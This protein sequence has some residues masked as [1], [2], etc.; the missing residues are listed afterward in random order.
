MGQ[1]TKYYSSKQEHM[2]ADYLGWSVVSGSGARAFH[3]GDIRSDD[4]LGECKTHVERV[5]RIVIYN[6]VWAKIISEAT[7]VFKTPVLFIDNGSQRV[8]STWCVIPRNVVLSHDIKP[9]HFETD[10][11]CINISKTQ[12]SF[13]HNEMIRQYKILHTNNNSY[14]AIV[15]SVGNHNVAIYRLDEFRNVFL[16]G[17]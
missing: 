8:D 7:S 1:P 12:T 13:N 6:K 17:E 11:S 5:D 4:F 10:L 16:G 2:I 3:P 15:A 9:V 14:V